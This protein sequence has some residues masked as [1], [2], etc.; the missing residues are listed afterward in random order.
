MYV[1]LCNAL[2]DRDVRAAARAG[3]A[4]PS[5][6]YGQCGV[7]PCCGK[8]APMMRDM[9]REERGGAPGFPAPHPPPA[10]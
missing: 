5:Q 4:R 9:L 6:V 8:C 3:A 1:C 7:S 2:T 10:E